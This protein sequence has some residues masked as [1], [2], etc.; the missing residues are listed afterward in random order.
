M[1][2]C[3]FCTLQNNGNDENGRW[4]NVIL[5]Q[6]EHLYLK[7][8]L[9]AF[10]SGY[11]LLNTKKHVTCLADCPEHVLEEYDRLAMFIAR[12]LSA[13]YHMPV[14]T[15]EHGGLNRLCGHAPRCPKGCI[16]HAHLHFM[17]STVRVQPLLAKRFR[18]TNLE[19]LC[20]VGAYRGQAYLTVH[21]AEERRLY[22]CESPIESQLIRRLLVKDEV[23]LGTWDWRRFPYRDA[24]YAT[25]TNVVKHFASV[26]LPRGFTLNEVIANVHEGRPRLHENSH[27]A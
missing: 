4:E 19:S 7:A 8:G 22:V 15:F 18:H 12:Q 1:N 17:P 23:G 9:G 20:E 6:S 16:E 26:S 14:V 2:N 21:E 13:L 5:G 11:L 24:V 25:V 27:F 10:G 3:V